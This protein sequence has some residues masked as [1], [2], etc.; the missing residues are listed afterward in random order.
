[1][2]IVRPHGTTYV[3]FKLTGKQLSAAQKRIHAE[4][5]K[6]GIIVHTVEAATGEEAWA[7][8]K[9]IIML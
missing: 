5:A 9:M 4:F 8:V 6:C 7:K 1:M 2:T 3:E